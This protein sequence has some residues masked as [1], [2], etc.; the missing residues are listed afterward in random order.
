VYR[1]DLPD[2]ELT[3]FRLG[4]VTMDRSLFD[5]GKE[6]R[7]NSN[8]VPILKQTCVKKPEQPRSQE[9]GGDGMLRDI[10]LDGHEP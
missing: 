8:V 1:F 6:V 2:L 5:E 10:N 3:Q 9:E 7:P 4:V